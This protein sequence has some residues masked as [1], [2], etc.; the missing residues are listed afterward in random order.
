MEAT[1][2]LSKI[3]LF[4]TERLTIE[5]LLKDSDETELLALQEKNHAD[6]YIK[7]LYS[8]PPQYVTFESE[9][10]Y[11]VNVKCGRNKRLNLNQSRFQKLFY[12][13]KT[14]NN[15]VVIGALELYESGSRLEFGLFIA[16]EHSNQ[17]FG[18]E[19]LHRAIQIVRESLP[20]NTEM[21]WECYA[22]NIASCKL[23]EAC[24]FKQQGNDS[25]I[26][27]IGDVKR[28]SRVYILQ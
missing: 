20:Q 12:V 25:Y 4:E 27:K 18:K 9:T 8:S 6:D 13:V 1:V 26:Y 7:T 16:K 24:G 19:T 11:N 28:Y 22:D 14:K 10:K 2:P 17:G 5:L 15:G 21:K 23:A 3:Q